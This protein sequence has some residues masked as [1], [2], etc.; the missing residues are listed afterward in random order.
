MIESNQQNTLRERLKTVIEAVR[1][2]I[3]WKPGCGE[4][5]LRKRIS[6]GHLEKNATLA[7]YHSVIWKVLAGP[8]AEVYL[9]KY[10][11][12]EYPTI[13]ANIENAWWLVMFDWNGVMETAFVVSNPQAYLQK[14]EFEDIGTLTEV[15]Q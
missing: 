8:D 12:T 15:M 7:D 2:Q 10:G 5:H 6:R 3:R 13:V 4:V 9:Y 1:Y 14:P 11:G